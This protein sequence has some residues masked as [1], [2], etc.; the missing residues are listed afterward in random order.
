VNDQTRVWAA[1]LVGALVGAGIGWLY[2][3]ASGKRLRDQMEPRLDQALRE[4][5][6]LGDTLNK[7]QAVASEGWRS[8][9]QIAGEAS[10]E[11]RAPRQSSPF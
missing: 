11:W 6:R 2:M 4:V 9:N 1:A 8:L 3:T 10:R 7:A 5:R